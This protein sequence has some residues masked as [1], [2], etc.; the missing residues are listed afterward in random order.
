LLGQIREIAGGAIVITQ[1]AV[2][3][4][5]ADPVESTTC[6]VKLNAP[7]VVGVPVI[8]PVDGFSTSPGGSDPPMIE[9][10]YGGTPPFTAKADE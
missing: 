9:N 6:A 5:A 1:F 10:V 7:Y 8:A 4:P 3:V 2:A